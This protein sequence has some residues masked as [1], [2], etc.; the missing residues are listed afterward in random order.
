LWNSFFQGNINIENIIIGCR[1]D[2]EEGLFIDLDATKYSGPEV[3]W[4][5]KLMGM[6]VTLIAVSAIACFMV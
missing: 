4:A 3:S 1:K 2:T 5:H 6:K